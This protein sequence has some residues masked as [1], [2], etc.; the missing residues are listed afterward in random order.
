MFI[1]KDNVT[2]EILEIEEIE[3]EEYLRNKPAEKKPKLSMDDMIR[4]AR[5]KKEAEDA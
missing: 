1:N 5:A 4:N 2:P 3:Y